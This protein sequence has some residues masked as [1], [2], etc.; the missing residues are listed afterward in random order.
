MHTVADA[1]IKQAICD[2]LGIDR[3]DE[4]TVNAE[5]HRIEIGMTALLVSAKTNSFS[6]SVCKTYVF[7]YFYAIMQLLN[8]YM[9]G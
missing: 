9:Q 3:Y 2:Y 8:D 5:L 7:S 6:V 1:E 4:K